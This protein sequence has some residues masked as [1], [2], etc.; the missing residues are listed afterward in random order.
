MYHNQVS[1]PEYI[2]IPFYPDEDDYV[3]I[4]YS[5]RDSAQVYLVIKAL[6]EAGYHIWFDAG[7]P[8]LKDWQKTIDEHIVHC[9]AFLLF[10]SEASL[11]SKYVT[12]E[13][14]K[15]GENERHIINAQLGTNATAI[16]KLLETRGIPN[17][18]K[19]DATPPTLEEQKV[20]RK[21]QKL[22]EMGGKYI[23]LDCNEAPFAFVDFMDEDRQ[24][25]EPLLYSMIN[26]GFNITREPDKRAGATHIQ[27]ISEATRDNPDVLK[28]ILAIPDVLIVCIDGCK[29][30]DGL[31]EEMLKHQHIQRFDGIGQEKLEKLLHEL[32]CHCGQERHLNSLDL[33]GFD[34]VV[35]DRNGT[36]ELDVVLLKYRASDTGVEKIE[37]SIV[38][39]DGLVVPV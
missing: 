14:N 20:F 11:A 18:G 3:F 30:P 35:L 34:N 13:I 10:Q 23:P 16:I 7:I 26:D 12:D 5:H 19:R 32:N 39:D 36:D 15:A 17:F 6:Y 28:R 22:M 8:A 33:L 24:K 1:K 2:S 38:N 27:F 9:H 37:D 31:P 29:L 21:L 25:I 4:S